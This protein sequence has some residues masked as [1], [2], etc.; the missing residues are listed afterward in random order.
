MRLILRLSFL[1]EFGKVSRTLTIDLPAHWLRFHYFF[2]FS[3]NICRFVHE[4]GSARFFLFIS[5]LGYVS[6]LSTHRPVMASSEEVLDEADDFFSEIPSLMRLR[7]GDEG[8]VEFLVPP[9]RDM[10]LYYDFEWFGSPVPPILFC[11]LL[12]QH[13]RRDS[14]RWNEHPNCAQYMHFGLFGCMLTQ[15]LTVDNWNNAEPYDNV[16]DFLLDFQRHHQAELA[17][18]IDYVRLKLYSTLS[19]AIGGPRGKVRFLSF[20][21]SFQ[22]VSVWLLFCV[23]ACSC[24]ARQLA[25]N[26]MYLLLDCDE[27]VRAMHSVFHILMHRVCECLCVPLCDL[28]FVAM[29]R[30]P[31]DQRAPLPLCIMLAVYLIFGASLVGFKVGSNGNQ[32]N[33]T[34]WLFDKDPER[35][36][37]VFQP[38]DP[39]VCVISSA[40][41]RDHCDSIGVQWRDFLCEGH[42]RISGELFCRKCLDHLG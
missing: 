11:P 37:A 16:F 36:T 5:L 21:F 33:H 3:C 2:F 6:L 20:C 38:T 12:R 30:M 10:Q 27:A 25:L 9:D 15:S 4:I 29:P 13:L 31:Q 19:N 32:Y 24:R 23:S 26:E 34:A 18:N 35:N 8:H 14:G 17:E 42:R 22:T 39:Q 1:R 40:A 41:F 7:I 28:I